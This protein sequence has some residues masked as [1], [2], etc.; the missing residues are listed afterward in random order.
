LSPP[1]D[2][3]R[4]PRTSSQH[5]SASSAIR[6]DILFFPSATL[7][8]L[9]RPLMFGTPASAR[10]TPSLLRRLKAGSSCPSP[11]SPWLALAVQ[12]T[13]A[14]SGTRLPSQR[15]VSSSLPGCAKESSKSTLHTVH[16]RSS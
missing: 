13:P 8:P 2:A 16:L 12:T 1:L 7:R 15:S 9:S 5:S 4:S 11:A 14:G 3:L 6:P 10:W